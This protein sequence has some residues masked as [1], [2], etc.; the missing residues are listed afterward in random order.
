MQTP[1]WHPAHDYG[2]F[3]LRAAPAAG[4]RASLVHH[5]SSHVCDKSSSTCLRKHCIRSYAPG[6]HI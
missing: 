2:H 6:L 1:S 4:P 3:I 5:A